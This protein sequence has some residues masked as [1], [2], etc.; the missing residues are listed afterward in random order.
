MKKAKKKAAKKKKAAAKKDEPAAEVKPD[1]AEEVKE[2]AADK[3]D[4]L[5]Q[6]GDAPVSD[7]SASKDSEEEDIEE[8]VYQG[9]TDLVKM[10]A[11][12]DF[13]VLMVGAGSIGS[14]AAIAMAKMGIMKCMIVDNDNI[15]LHNQANQIYN[16]KQCGEMKID[17][18]KGLISEYNHNLETWAWAYTNKLIETTDDVQE[19]CG[20]GVVPDVIICAVD[21]MVARKILWEYSKSKMLNVKLFIDARIGA[22]AAECYAI[23]PFMPDEVEKFEKNNLD[24]DEEIAPLKCTEKSIIFP[25]QFTASWISAALFHLANDTIAQAP[26]GLDFNF[27]TFEMFQDKRP[28]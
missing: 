13:R 5:E 1:E 3:A 15:E 19:V 17:A 18:L 23:Q 14:F 26:M 16:W 2:A 4:E 25:V 12:A 8:T 24:E 22:T 7:E 20:E 9:H 28:S 11:L 10:D 21:N 27:Q 6:G